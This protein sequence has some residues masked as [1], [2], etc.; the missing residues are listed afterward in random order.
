LAALGDLGGLAC[1]GLG[2]V[3][4]SA[5]EYSALIASPSA[6]VIVPAAIELRR[7]RWRET[8]GWAAIFL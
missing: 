8:S 2:E 5:A 7:R 6:A 4:S 3:L 1:A